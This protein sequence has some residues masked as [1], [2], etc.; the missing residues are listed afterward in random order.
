[1][2]HLPSRYRR[3]D[4][5]LAALPV[6][7]PMLL[8]ELDGFLTGILIS[9][10]AI[11]PDEWMQSIWDL[12]DGL[13]VGGVAPFERPLDVRWFADA[14]EAP[15]CREI[16]RRDL[17]RGKPQPIF[18]IDERNGDLLWEMWL[19]ALADALE[20]RPDAWD[21]LAAHEDARVG[22]AVACLAR[23]TAV[24]DGGGQLDSMAINALDDT[25]PADIARSLVVLHA[26]RRRARTATRRTRRLLPSKVGRNDPCPCGSGRKSKRCCGDGDP[27]AG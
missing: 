4:G 15:M 16:E 13:D 6:E 14:V 26:A 19:A 18:D 8:T 23:L 3:L 20:M 11:A 2:R 12:D 10:D 27:A 5:A 17:T 7:E 9:P 25:A 22:E 21:R 1:M 24:A